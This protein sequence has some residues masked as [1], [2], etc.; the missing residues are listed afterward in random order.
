MD[1]LRVIIERDP[2]DGFV[3]QCVDFDI[4][5]IGES[6]EA[7]VQDFVS[8]FMRHVAAS[9][10]MGESPL[11]SERR[12]PQEYRDRWDQAQATARIREFDIPDFAIVNAGDVHVSNLPRHGVAMVACADAVGAVPQNAG[13]RRSHPR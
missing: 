3:A 12:P 9:V 1:Q 7:A 5:G 6:P 13:G 10:H 2:V 4:I 11:S 8:A